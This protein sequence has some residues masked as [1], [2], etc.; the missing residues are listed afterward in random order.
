MAFRNDQF[1]PHCLLRKT[2]LQALCS[3]RITLRNGL[4]PLN[5]NKGGGS[6]ANPMHRWAHVF[7]LLLADDFGDAVVVVARVK[8]G[9][10]RFLENHLSAAVITEGILSE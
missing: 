1:S 8:A 2:L 10:D 6:N 4:A 5:L 9:R 7:A 3:L